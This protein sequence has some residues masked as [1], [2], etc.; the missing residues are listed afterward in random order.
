MLI[1]DENN[2]QIMWR[3]VGYQPD[4]RRVR[5]RV[6]YL[7]IVHNIHLCAENH[8]SHRFKPLKWRVLYVHTLT[9]IDTM[10]LYTFYVYQVCVCVRRINIEEGIVSYTRP[11][12]LFTRVHIMCILY[13]VLYLYS[14]SILKVTQNNYSRRQSVLDFEISVC[15]LVC[16]LFTWVLK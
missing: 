2:M 9:H 7:E 16:V 14:V 13:T 3:N 1:T 15:F 12:M 6:L 10:Y 8:V 5:F 11:A 4:C